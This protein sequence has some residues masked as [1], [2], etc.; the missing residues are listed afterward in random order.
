[1]PNGTT[2]L[3]ALIKRFSGIIIK[4]LEEKGALADVTASLKEVL[5]G[6][7]NI[8]ADNPL[9][10]FDA[11]Q[12]SNLGDFTT[13]TNLRSLLQLMGVP[14]IADKPFYACLVT[15]R[16]DSRLSADRAAY[17]DNL[18]GSEEA[19]I[20]EHPDGTSEED[21][22]VITPTELFEYKTLLL[23]LSNLTQVTT[24][25]TYIR[26]D[27]ANDHLNDS[28]VFPDD[29]PT[30]TKVVPVRLCPLSVTMK[31]TLQSAV[32]EGEA[33]SILWRYVKQSMS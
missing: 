9:Q 11:F 5:G 20:Y 16:W 24:I 7:A 27:G 23:D 1:M 33:R 19:G 14:D 2:E 25:R 32:G 18:L 21:A 3:I 28:A 15:D 12:K 26:V 4:I 13:Q 30:G 29:F 17:I 6:G 22:V 10:T 31:L 8:S